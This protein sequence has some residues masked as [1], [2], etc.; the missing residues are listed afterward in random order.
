MIE[1]I[2]NIVLIVVLIDLLFLLFIKA[3]KDHRT[4][5]ISRATEKQIIIK[6]EDN[7]IQLPEQK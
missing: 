6:K 3:F 7:I 2:A 4:K 1:I 5:I